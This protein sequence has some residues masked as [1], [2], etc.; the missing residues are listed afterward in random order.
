MYD[1]CPKLTIKTPDRHHSRYSGVFSFLV[2]NFEQILY[3]V[4]VFPL[5]TLSKYRLEKF[6]VSSM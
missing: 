4:M 5:L 1:I 6:Y 3:I 2:F